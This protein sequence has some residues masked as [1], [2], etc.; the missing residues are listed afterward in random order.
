M[1]V[2]AVD[3]EDRIE[4]WNSQMEVMYAMPRWQALDSPLRGLPGRR[5]WKSSIAYGRTP[6]IHN[7]YKFRLKTPAGEHAHQRCHRSPGHTQFK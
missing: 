4:S 7:L 3:L 6:G 2:M 5:S 1:G